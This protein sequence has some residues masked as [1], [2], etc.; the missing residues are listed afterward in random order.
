MKTAE[1]KLILATILVIS[2]LVLLFLGFY[3][4]PIGEIDN[5]VLVAFGETS[6]FAGSLFG[7]QS[8]EKYKFTKKLKE[9]ERKNVDN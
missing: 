4:I 2:G 6:T 3:Q 9:N 7:I 5:S 1:I 8:I